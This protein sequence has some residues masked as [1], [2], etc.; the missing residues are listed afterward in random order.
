[1]QATLLFGHRHQLPLRKKGEVIGKVSAQESTEEVI[2]RVLGNTAERDEIAFAV[3]RDGNVYTRTPDD[4]KTLDDIGLI[5]RLRAKRPVNDIPNWI[6]AFN[7]D[8]QSGLRIGVA[9]P[10]GD[11]FQ[12]LRKTAAKNFGYGMALVFVALIG[13]VPFANHISRDVK[14]VTAGAERVAHG[15]LQTRLPVKSGN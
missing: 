1:M 4:K 8:P 6:T 3:D 13:I 15:D 11:T 14:L 5:A 9:R 2:K 7:F 10:V 12:E